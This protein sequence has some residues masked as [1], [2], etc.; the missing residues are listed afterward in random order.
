M[1]KTL[2]IIGDP[3]NSLNV[4][5]DSSLAMAQGALSLGIEVHW[6]TPERIALFNGVPVLS[7]WTQL[8]E[9]KNGCSPVSSIS[10]CQHFESLANYTHILIRKDP[11]FDTDYT[12]LCWILSQCR[13]G[14]VINDPRA[15]LCL[16]EKLMPWRLL[17]RGIVP[18][19]MM[20]PTMVSITKSTILEF[21]REQ[22]ASAESFL[23]TF[24]NLPEFRN[25]RFKLICKPWRGHAGRGIQVFESQQAIEEWLNNESDHVTSSEVLTAHWIVQPLLPEI[26]SRGDR[27]VFIING[28][29]FFDFVRRPASGRIEANLAQGGS[30]TLEPMPTELKDVCQQLAH[31]LKQEGVLIAGLDFIGLK[32]TE[33]NITSPTGIRTY[34]SLTGQ[35]LTKNI[36]ETLLNPLS[37]A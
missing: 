33:V 6:T 14:Q 26:F 9:I 17:S 7:S 15:L 29:V 23:K 28:E 3:L 22:F 5:T 24:A 21:A 20:V 37:H 19:H 25:F 13:P 30:A 34:E 11:P 12:D 8:H 4:P 27:R 2:L 18:A 10:R 31:Y 36:M 16:H 35:E 1:N 32:L